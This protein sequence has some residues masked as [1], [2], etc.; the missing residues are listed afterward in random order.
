MPHKFHLY[1]F[2]VFYWGRPSFGFKQFRNCIRKKK[3]KEIINIICLFNLFNKSVTIH[4]LKT[5]PFP[6]MISLLVYVG[7]SKEDINQEGEYLKASKVKYKLFHFVRSSIFFD[8]VL[9]C[10]LSNKSNLI[11]F[12]LSLSF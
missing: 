9:K 12:I 3:E 8:S 4:A 1:L 7:P 5:L 6:A 10:T 11:F 2:F